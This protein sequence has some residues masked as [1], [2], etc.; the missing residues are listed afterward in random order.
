M[1]LPQSEVPA[2][3]C[4]EA[5]SLHRTWPSTPANIHIF[6]S[7]IGT[8]AAEKKGDTGPGSP[9]RSKP[10]KKLRLELKNAF[11]PPSGQRSSASRHDSVIGRLEL[12]EQTL[13]GR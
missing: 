12:E 2:S 9:G 8:D 1:S 13:P 10:V 5:P 11:C 4:S 6:R 3:N 7:A